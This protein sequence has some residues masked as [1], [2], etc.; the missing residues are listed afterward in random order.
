MKHFKYLLLCGILIVSCNKDEDAAP[1][2]FKDVPS[3]DIVSVEM[4]DE[5]L[6]GVPESSEAGRMQLNHKWWRQA[7]SVIDYQGC[8]GYEDQEIT[9]EDTY[10]SFTSDGDFYVKN[11][12]NGSSQYY[13]T[14][15]WTNDE[16]S[17][18]TLGKFPDV[19][20]K[21]T[22]LNENQVVYASHQPQ[23]GGC[24][25]VTWEEFVEPM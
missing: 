14:W 7:E 22:A 2:F 20:F 12:V 11:G 8:E 25:V 9:L 5:I 19:E 24:N 16:K 1:N 15:E 10:F 4:R 18:I 6:T 17:A 13:T 3:G 23:G 21:I